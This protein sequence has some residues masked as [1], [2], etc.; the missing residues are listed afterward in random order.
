VI[1]GI[2]PK[3]SVLSEGFMRLRHGK[4]ASGGTGYFSSFNKLEYTEI[5]LG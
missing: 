4:R 2:K 5:K 1:Q 3:D